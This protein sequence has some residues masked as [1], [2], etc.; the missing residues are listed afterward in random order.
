MYRDQGNRE[1]QAKDGGDGRSN[2]DDL[3]IGITGRIWFSGDCHLYEPLRM[4]VSIGQY[5]PKY[6][7]SSHFSK[8]YPRIY[9]ILPS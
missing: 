1:D 3:V 6:G 9:R 4:V 8:A 7:K 2:E 5:V